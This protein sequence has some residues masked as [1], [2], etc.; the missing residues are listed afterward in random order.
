MANT[1]F[2]G[3]LGTESTYMMKVP[4]EEGS[5]MMR[6]ISEVEDELSLDGETLRGWIEQRWIRPTMD[7]GEPLFD[8]ADMARARLIA[9]LRQDFNVTDEAMPVMLKLLD[10][11]Y[12]LRKALNDLTQAI[13]SCPQEVQD[14]IS[15]KLK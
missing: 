15:N 8:E 5:G 6:R 10:Q 13:K 14:I 7:E 1:G 9:E 2:Q 12:A 3:T 4:G 11:V